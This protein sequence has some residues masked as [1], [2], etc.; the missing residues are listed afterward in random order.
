MTDADIYL[1]ISHI[2]FSP[3]NRIPSLFSGLDFQEDW[4]LPRNELELV[5]SQPSHFYLLVIGPEV[6]M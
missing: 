5:Q 2:P 6:N 3:A 1:S 4:L